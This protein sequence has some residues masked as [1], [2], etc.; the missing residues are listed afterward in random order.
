MTSR[1]YQFVQQVFVRR[2]I[3]P[4]LLRMEGWDD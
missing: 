1:T 3:P 4:G 2:N